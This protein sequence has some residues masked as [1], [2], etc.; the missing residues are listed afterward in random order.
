L[1]TLSEI[2]ALDKND[3]GERAKTLEAND[4]SLLVDLLNEKYDTIRYHS[5]LLLQYRS[6]EKEDV[7][8]YINVFCGKL[9]STNS[10]Q[11][12]IG[13]LLVAEN[14]RWDTG[15][16]ISDAIEDYLK[17]L[18]DEKPITVRQCIQSL[19]K[20]IPYKPDLHRIISERL[21]AMDIS[22]IRE[23]MR[24]SILLDILGVLIQ[25][26]KH[27]HSDQIEDYIQKALLGGILDRK[28]IKEVEARMKQPAPTI[29]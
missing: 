7:Y 18:E 4:I 6:A 12:S 14:T 13:V 28:A 22:T 23:T 10:Y 21:L 2:M 19:S 3:L 29:K 24:K 26:Q 5:L 20:I 27:L 16:N 1:M 11:R 9:A 8:P 17:L 15:N 25:L